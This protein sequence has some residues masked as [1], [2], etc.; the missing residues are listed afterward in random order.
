MIKKYFS[1]TVLAIFILCMGVSASDFCVRNLFAGDANDSGVSLN[2]TIQEPI[3]A[4]DRSVRGSFEGLVY[5]DVTVTLLKEG[6]DAPLA[7][8]RDE[9]LAN[10]FFDILV[11]EG[12]LAENDVLFVRFAGTQVEGGMP[13]EAESHHVTV[14]GRRVYG[15]PVITIPL[16][17][18]S[19]TVSGTFDENA[20][21][22]TISIH[23]LNDA[24]SP[25]LPELGSIQA[26]GGHFEVRLNRVLEAE[27]SIAAAFRGMLDG[28]IQEGLSPSVQVQ[29]LPPLTPPVLSEPLYEGQNILQGTYDAVFGTVRMAALARDAEGHARV[30]AT[31]SGHD[32]SFELTLTR[33]ETLIEGEQIRVSMAPSGYRQDAK[34]EWIAVQD[35][36]NLPADFAVTG[37]EDVTPIHRDEYYYEKGDVLQFDVTVENLNYIPGRNYENL[38]LDLKLWTASHWFSQR[39]VIEH[40]GRSKVVRFQMDTSNPEVRPTFSRKAMV[41]ALVNGYPGHLEAVNIANDRFRSPEQFH[42]V[43][44]G[45]LPYLDYENGRPDLEIVSV[46]NVTQG[47]EAPY[48]KTDHLNFNVTVRNNRFE[49]VREVRYVSVTADLYDGVRVDAIGG[50]GR[51]DRMLE[52][53]AVIPVEVSLARATLGDKTL[54][55]TVD[56]AGFIPETNERNNVFT[57]PQTLPLTMERRPLGERQVIDSDLPDLIVEHIENVSEIPGPEYELGMP[58][59]F[60]VTFRNENFART[61]VLRNVPVK[62]RFVNEMGF[63]QVVP[64]LE[65]ETVVRFHVM[66]EGGHIRPGEKHIQAEV[67]DLDNVEEF[68]E[69]NNTLDMDGTI[70][71][72]VP[73]VFRS[74]RP[75]DFWQPKPDLTVTDIRNVTGHPGPYRKGERLTFEVTVVNQTHQPGQVFR[76]VAAGLRVVN[77][78]GIHQIQNGFEDV[79]VFRI[80]LDTGDPFVRTGEKHI[81]AEV[82]DT[83]TI[84][85]DNTANNTLELEE[86]IVILPRG[87]EA[88]ELSDIRVESIR[89]E[90]EHPVRGDYVTPIVRLRNDGQGE[91]GLFYSSVT[92]PTG[93]KHSF[94]TP[95]LLPGQSLETRL[96]GK[97][98]MITSP[99]RNQRFSVEADQYERVVESDEENNTARMEFEVPAQGDIHSRDFYVDHVERYPENVVAGAYHEVNL[100]DTIEF[101]VQI[102]DNDFVYGQDRADRVQARMIAGGWQ[103][104]SEEI[105]SNETCWLHFRV[106]ADE[107]GVGIWPIRVE[108]DPHLDFDESNEV[109]NR[110]EYPTRLWVMPQGAYELQPRPDLV[111]ES[112]SLT[113]AEPRRGDAVAVGFRVRNAGNARSGYFTVGINADREQGVSVENLNAG[114]VFE[115]NARSPFIAGSDIS[116]PQSIRVTADLWNRVEEQ[117]EENNS[118]TRRLDLTM[119]FYADTHD[120][121]ISSVTQTPHSTLRNGFREVNLNENIGLEVFVRDNDY[122]PIT[123]EAVLEGARIRLIVGDWSA[124]ENVRL[125]N[126]RGSIVFNVPAQDLGLGEHAVTVRVMPPEGIEESNTDNNLYER[127]MPVLVLAQGALE[128]M[129]WPELGIAEF[130]LDPNPVHVG[131]RIYPWLRVTNSGDRAAGEFRV[132][133]TNYAAPIPGGEG[134]GAFATYEHVVEGLEPGESHVIDWRDLYHGDVY[135][136][137]SQAGVFSLNAQ[138]DPDNEVIET[139]DDNNFGSAG[140]R[141]LPRQGHDLM[142]GQLFADNVFEHRPAQELF[143]GEVAS[144]QVTVTNN[145]SETIPDFGVAFYP[146]EGAMPVT[147]RNE[148]PLRSLDS[149]TF[150]FSGVTYDHPGQKRAWVDV[151]DEGQIQELNENNNHSETLISV[152]QD[153]RGLDGYTP[154]VIEEPVHA[155]DPLIRVRCDERFNVLADESSWIRIFRVGRDGHINA[156]PTGSSLAQGSLVEVR[157]DGFGMV[158]DGESL[159]AVHEITREGE[160]LRLMS[161]IVR[162][163]PREDFQSPV[164]QEPVNVLDEAVRGTCDA[165]W[166]GTV[167]V[168]L[169]GDNGRPG[170]DSRGMA[171]C[172]NGLFE[173]PLRISLEGGDRLFPVLRDATKEGVRISE[174]IGPAVDVQGER[175]AEDAVDYAAPA[176]IGPVYAFDE[177]VRITF[178]PE[179][180]RLSDL[181]DNLVILGPDPLLPRQEHRLARV[182]T[183][184]EGEI[185]VRLAEDARAGDEI[186]AVHSERLPRTGEI[187]TRTSERI[188]VLPREDY[189]PPRIDEPVIAGTRSVEGAC[190]PNTADGEISIHLMNQWGGRAEELGST[191][192]CEEGRFRVEL[193]RALEEEEQIAPLFH[194]NLETHVFVNQDQGNIV[195]VAAEAEEKQGGQ[196]QVAPKKKTASFF[197]RLFIDDP[198]DE[199]E[200]PWFKKQAQK[201]KEKPK[202]KMTPA[203]EKIIQGIEKQIPKSF[204]EQLARKTLLKLIRSYETK[205]L[206]GFM[207]LVSEEFISGDGKRAGDLENSL[208]TDFEELINP[209]LKIRSINNIQTEPFNSWLVS[210]S[211]DW[212]RDADV[213]VG[214]QRKKWLYEGRT[215]FV[216]HVAMTEES[217]L[218]ALNDPKNFDYRTAQWMSELHRLRGDLFFGITNLQGVLLIT[219]GVAGRRSTLDNQKVTSNQAAG[220]TGANDPSQAS[221]VLQNETGEMFSSAAEHRAFNFVSGST[222]TFF[223]PAPAVGDLYIDFTTGLLTTNGSAKIA[224]VPSLTLANFNDYTKDRE[225]T[226]TTLALTSGPGF[227][228]K[229]RSGT[230]AKMYLTTIDTGPPTQVEFSY[231]HQPDGSGNLVSTD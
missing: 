135:V 31:G 44:P 169:A 142:A 58:L 96:E 172:E 17:Q 125:E 181:L 51:L 118:L 173:I 129:R 114:E 88:I 205:D 108:V 168:F 148:T 82:N 219:P 49:E 197:K 52:Q 50:N 126:G 68:Y 14:L 190:H 83:G 217:I 40:M 48:A 98:I 149:Q 78:L 55:W 231:S 224:A 229:T 164:I 146:E 157:H 37:V 201:Q 128:P 112:L 211:A 23:A 4:G 133:M 115:G 139:V 110:Y 79:G 2:L 6:D 21:N 47:L 136:T 183:H 113:P 203:Q 26:Q 45:E 85:E 33:G 204:L 199:P 107:A 161:E 167:H 223:F 208:M 62:L 137:A 151:D 94:E 130:R 38:P 206:S 46:E 70:Q 186:Y 105:L 180:D 214:G 195:T 43:E 104:E 185:N 92:E 73:P 64:V 215:Q 154:P 10:P 95:N 65:E 132:R 141:V 25:Q 159:I 63:S 122:N 80:E 67:D 41:E 34:S 1:F 212:N 184:G 90:P 140:T 89:I 200:S 182:T 60:D 216:F 72:I 162:A 39:H 75:S 230:F 56:L 20:A 19:Q 143:T 71:M 116:H 198:V 194:G 91:T 178:D 16:M 123:Q 177:N 124:E 117:N 61:G 9:G 24:G 191:R 57:Y 76:S 28:R 84:L 5:Q 74:P 227:L 144:F 221:R 106:P 176:I 35:S 228:V 202:E 36:D 18:G 131:E 179:M 120:L 166:G 226:S 111:M 174:N 218:K 121:Y 42:V 66:T 86:P 101:R 7:E 145:G 119:P 103:G 30:I 171:P 163:L 97:H 189:W 134:A 210:M 81:V 153:E 12:A 102:R 127:A 188:T 29:A 193:N 225:P 13:V 152:Q 165:A 32:G 170:R 222:E 220:E 155:W 150:F 59:D 11:D 69:D 8:Y 100:G 192:A 93:K 213:E 156:M 3:H 53:T 175:R 22:V 207:E 158:H 15:N 27:E 147:R 209:R 138:V 99:L 54:K 87:D 196:A 77:E 160:T 109:N 187:I